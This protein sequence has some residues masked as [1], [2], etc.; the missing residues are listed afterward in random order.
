VNKS[1]RFPLLHTS[2]FVMKRMKP[3]EN[4]FP[5]ITNDRIPSLPAPNYFLTPASRLPTW[6]DEEGRDFPGEDDHYSGCFYPNSQS[7]D[8]EQKVT[9]ATA[10]E[11]VGY[12]DQGHALS[13][14]EVIFMRKNMDSFETFSEESFGSS[15]PN[16]SFET[17]IL[18]VM[19]C[20]DAYLNASNKGNL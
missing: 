18:R 1:Q 13:V 20:T 4:P 2:D 12:V 10:S 7:P 5:R 6:D 9:G 3:N 11:G 14:P 19:S 17:L 16:S 15:L 8:Q